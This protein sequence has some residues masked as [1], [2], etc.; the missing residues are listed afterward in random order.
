MKERSNPISFVAR[1]TFLLFIAV[2]SIGPLVWVLLSSFKSNREILSSSFALPTSYALDG[3]TTAL[4]VAPIGDFYVNSIVISV[5][6]TLLNV[7]AVSMAAYVIARFSFRGKTKLTL[8]LAS[9]LLI[10]TASLLMPIYII[11]TRIG[12]YDTR[13]GLIL[14]YAAL[15]LPTSLFIMRSYFL[16]VPKEMEEAAYVDGAGFYRTFFTII[17]PIVRPGMA[18]AAILQFL[19]AWNEFMFALIL[20]KSQSVR[21][22]PLALNYFTSQFSFNYTALFAA[23]VMVVL[24]SIVIYVLLQKQVTDSMVEGSI[25]G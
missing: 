12:L 8:L 11:M 18:T 17:L 10:P 19:M 2:I 16:N 15:G 14:V 13:T 1:W 25:K 23:I 4:S 21:T 5:S 7:L 9:S 22:L 24:P 3:Y 6:S 20:T